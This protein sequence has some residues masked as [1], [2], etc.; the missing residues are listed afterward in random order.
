LAVNIPLTT[1]RSG[2]FDR[3]TYTG[4]SP[5]CPPTQSAWLYTVSMQMLKTP[6]IVT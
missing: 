2:N 5:A 3:C 6:S 1:K 4:M